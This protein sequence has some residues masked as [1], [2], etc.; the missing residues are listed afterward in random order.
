MFEQQEIS[1]LQQAYRESWEQYCASLK[2]KA[3]VG[4]DLCIL[5]ASDQ[6]QADMYEK[7]LAWRRTVGL[8]PL[9]TRFSVVA[10]PPGARIGS[11]GATLRLLAQLAT[12]GDTLTKK[13]TLII[14]S[15]GD[16][17]RLPHCSATGK[18]FA[19]VPRVLPDGR[20]S[21]LFDEFLISLSG[22]SVGASTG[23]LVASGDVLLVFDH[24]QLAFEHSG[25]IGVAAAAPLETGRRH[26]V[27]VVSEEEQGV[28]A[29]LHKPEVDKLRRWNGILDD[30]QVLIDT[31]LVW[32]DST[33]AIKMAALAKEDAL[34][35]LCH[36]PSA[37]SGS[38]NFYGDLVLPLAR[39]TSYE[40]YLND[41]SDGAAT[42]EIRRA[43]E[44]IWQRMR[45]TPL[46]CARLCPAMFIHFGTSI[47]YWTTVTS[48]NMAQ[49][50]CGWTNDVAAVTVAEGKPL[51]L[52]N[53]AVEST[54]VDGEQAALII[55]SHI[56]GPLSWQGACLLSNVKTR[57]VLHLSADVVL[58]QLPL[59]EGYVTRVYGVRDDPKKGVSS[60]QGTF[61][62]R[63][64]NAWLEAFRI[65]TEDLWAGI[66]QEKRSLWNARLY[67]VC[68]LR[69]ESLEMTLPLQGEAAPT[70][71]WLQTWRTAARVSLAESFVRASSSAILADIQA[72]EDYTVDRRS[73]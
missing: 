24:R 50:V 68:A 17:R 55:D 26:G 53:S 70:L 46:H 12:E 62:G 13:R 61:M 28:R 42:P 4:W 14:H 48:K 3:K 44:V 37:E 40:D 45:D 56:A 66:A 35:G 36:A 59:D 73:W 18:L 5:T 31:G 51:S 25:V 43:R 64:W 52:I 33:T 57:R 19:R 39:S 38:I 71:S 34:A 9:K 49:T 54:L 16:S 30:G 60:A 63:P 20:A 58:H 10:D 69:E 1:F 32:L 7:Q 8:L 41:T 22:S 47:E 65:S 72:I 67:P 6:P 15:G 23:V 21:T 2:P 27:Y 11:G 29:F